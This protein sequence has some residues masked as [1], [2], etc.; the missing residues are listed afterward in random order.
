MSDET[1]SAN[2]PAGDTQRSE[3]DDYRSE[4]AIQRVLDAIRGLR[5]GQ[6]TVI[7]Q[8]GVIIQIERTQRTRLKKSGR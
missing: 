4:E 5:Y 3:G 1:G 6:V 8:D 7:V 2:S